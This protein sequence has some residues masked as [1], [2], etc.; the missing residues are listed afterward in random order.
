[1]HL[2]GAAEAHQRFRRATV[3]HI[4]AG[5]CRAD[6]DG[7]GT[8]TVGRGVS[9]EGRS[10][11]EVVQPHLPM[12]YGLACR[13][14]GDDAEDAVQECLV[15]AFK[16]FDGLRDEAAAGAW[17][18]KILLN[19]VRDRG[20]Q[21]Q[22]QPE[23][24]PVDESYSLFRKLADEDP[25]PYSD[26]L[27]LDFLSCFSVPDVWAVLDELPDHYRTPLVLVHMYGVPAKEVAKALDLPMN[28]L[29]S[30]LHRGRKRF[31]AALWEYAEQ[32]DLLRNRKGALQ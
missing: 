28:T 1:M 10:F 21:Q 13:L 7:P 14:T 25:L 5:V 15:K 32:H 30:H 4:L 19:T 9:E 3:R 12:L 6:G 22:R 24:V 11:R 18:R 27:H 17:L 16:A 20:R 31:E 2:T 8:S 23:E 29:L 26:S